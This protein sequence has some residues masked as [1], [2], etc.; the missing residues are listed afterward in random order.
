MKRIQTE[1]AIFFWNL[2]VTTGMFS[3]LKGGG[4]SWPDGG[5]RGA[6]LNPKPKARPHVLMQFLEDG[7]GGQE[8]HQICLGLNLDVRSFP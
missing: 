3:D 5:K 1:A 4:S 6:W 8:S 7:W 2:A